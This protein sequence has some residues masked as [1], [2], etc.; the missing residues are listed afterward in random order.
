MSKKIIVF[1]TDRVGDLIYFSPCLKNIKD[2]NKESSITLVCSKYNYQVAKNYKF[3]DKFIIIDSS[4]LLISLLKNFRDFFFTKY[5][6]LF[7]HDGKN[8]S[9]LISCFVRSKIKSTIC[10]VKYKKLLSFSYQVFRPK[11]FIL[12][13]FFDNFLYC[14][15]NYTSDDK[16]IHYQTLYFNILEKL[17]FHIY[18]KKNIFVLDSAFSDIYNSFFINNINNKYFLFHFDEKWD[19]CNKID[20]EN[21]LALIKKI[22]E[23]NKIVIT[24]GI[25]KFRFLEILKKEFTTFNFKDNKFIVTNK[26]KKNIIC[27]IE[28][29][30]LNLLAYFI[31]NSEKNISYHSGPIVHISPSF[32]REII[33]IIPIN[34]N[35]EL[36]RW[37]PTVSKYRRINFEEL[38]N[39]FLN[40]FKI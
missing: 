24:T 9:Y 4:S 17:N 18:S 3:V 40:N 36:D 2:N 20:F 31:K 6:Y 35:D 25:K 32:D 37:I 5:T 23:G 30:P 11:K 29:L 28:N 10:F 13:L 22:S 19:R 26:N 7:Q 21:S 38:N 15:E 33:D 16:R 1:K 12:K 27:V 8:R 34:K 39:D 14:D